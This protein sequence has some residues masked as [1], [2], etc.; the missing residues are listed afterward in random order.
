[1]KVISDATVGENAWKATVEC[2]DCKSVLE[3]EEADVNK[4]S[5]GAMGDYETLYYVVCPVCDGNHTFRYPN[6]PIPSYI[7]RRIK[8]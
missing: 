1:M 6:D 5:F 7:K 4:G 3:I 2:R 8:S